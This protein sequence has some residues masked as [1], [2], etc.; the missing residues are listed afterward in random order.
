ME[1]HRAR[2]R[3]LRAVRHFPQRGRTTPST[4][5]SISISTGSSPPPTPTSPATSRWTD[6]SPIRA[7]SAS[8]PAGTGRSTPIRP[9]PST[10]SQRSRSLWDQVIAPASLT[11]VRSGKMWGYAAGPEGPAPARAAPA[12]CAP[13]DASRTASRRAGRSC[14]RVAGDLSDAEADIASFNTTLIWSFAALGLGLILGDDHPGALR[15]GAASACLGSARRASAKAAHA[16]SKANS[17]PRS[18]RSR[19]AEQPD[20]ALGRSRGPRAHARV[21]SRAFP[22]D[23]AHRAL[24]TRPRS[25]RVRSPR[26][27]QRQVAHHAPAGRP[28][29]GAGAGGRRARRARQPHR[30]ARGRRRPRARAHAHA[31][32]KAASPSTSTW[33]RRSPFAA[34]ARTWRRWPAT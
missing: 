31:H 8:S 21:E 3:R 6:A 11:T 15:A 18:R 28:L 7:S 26:W 27:C 12:H 24:P 14:S 34:S 5:S 20:R 19:R 10:L 25:R 33:R 22:E 32:R 16:G 17:R 9:R 1:H 23:A 2:G 4:T 30:G 13:R 29:S